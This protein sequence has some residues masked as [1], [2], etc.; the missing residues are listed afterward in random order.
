MTGAFVHTLPELVSLSGDS[1]DFNV[2]VL[3]VGSSS[4]EASLGQKTVQREIPQVAG[5]TVENVMVGLSS[6]ELWYTKS[7]DPQIRVAIQLA[8]GM[9]QPSISTSMETVSVHVNTT[10][11]NNE[12]EN[13]TI[14]TNHS[15]CS[16]SLSFGQHLFTHDKRHLRVTARV[17]SRT[18]SAMSVTLR[19]QL[20][21]ATGQPALIPSSVSA[22]VGEEVL[23]AARVNVTQTISGFSA[24]CNGT[25]NFSIQSEGSFSVLSD[26]MFGETV[27]ANGLRST[28][29]D[30]TGL[31]TLYNVR[32]YP[33]VRSMSVSCTLDISLENGER[34]V[35]QTTSPASIAVREKRIV[36][37]YAHAEKYT[38][39]N[40][41][42]VNGV[43][44]SYQL[45]WTVLYSTGEVSSSAICTSS[46]SSL[47]KVDSNCS[48]IYFDG[49]ET[50]G[51]SVRIT[52]MATGGSSVELSFTVWAPRGKMELIAEDQE[53]NL[54]ESCGRYQETRI[55]ALAIFTDGT[56]DIQV[57]L[58]PPL[59]G[60]LTFDGSYISQTTAGVVRGMSVGNTSVSVSSPMEVTPAFVS[61]V[62]DTVNT[63]YLDVF[64]VSDIEI[65][66]AS[67]EF[68]MLGSTQ[69]VSISVQQRTVRHSF[70][71]ELVAVAVFSDSTT[72][73]VDANEVSVSST[74]VEYEMPYLQPLEGS[75]ED[76]LDVMALCASGCVNVTTNSTPPVS[77]KVNLT[78]D[79]SSYIVPFSDPASVVGFPTSTRVKVYL[80]H[81]DGFEVDV[82]GSDVNI[83]VDNHLMYSISGGF[84][85]V[86]AQTGWTGGALVSVS[87]ENLSGSVSVTVANMD[88]VLVSFRPYPPFDGSDEVDVTTLHQTMGSSYQ[89]ALL[90]AKA[91]LTNGESVILK[92]SQIDITP[93]S[94]V[95][96][97]GVV[98]VD[99]TSNSV[100]VSVTVKGTAMSGQK[101]LTI[102]SNMPAVISIGR[103]W[104][105]G[106]QVDCQLTLSGGVQVNSLFQNEDPSNPL[107]TQL[108]EFSSDGTDAVSVNSTGFLTSLQNLR[109]TVTITVASGSVSNSTQYMP[110]VHPE[111]GEIDIGSETEF[112]L[113]PI[114]TN[115]N[116]T[117][118]VYLNTGPSSVG[119]AEVTLSFSGELNFVSADA[120]EDISTGLL[121]VEEESKKLRLGCVM[122]SGVLGER[123]ELAKLNFRTGGSTGSVTFSNGEVLYTTGT[124]FNPSKEN[125]DK[126]SSAVSFTQSV[127]S[128]S[129]RRR[130]A[131]SGA[132][133]DG[134]INGDGV[135]D[136]LDTVV[137]Q[138][139]SLVQS[140]GFT[141]SLGTSINSS[142]NI[143]TIQ[144]AVAAI[145]I[146]GDGIVSI[147]NV[148]EIERLANNEIYLLSNFS[149]S[150]LGDTCES[151]TLSGCL[152]D[153]DNEPPQDKPV[154]FLYITSSN[155]NFTRVFEGIVWSSSGTIVFSHSD[156]FGGSGVYGGVLEV[157]LQ[158]DSCFSITGTV[159]RTGLEGN[160]TVGV[161][162]FHGRVMNVGAP[163]EIQGSSFQ[164]L[165]GSGDKNTPPM[166]AVRL[167]NY[168]VGSGG[169]E[170]RF[171]EGLSY[172]RN[173]VCEQPITPP[174]SSSVIAPSSSVSPSTSVSV[175]AT[176]SVFTTSVVEP[177]TT[178]TKIFTSSEATSSS[179]SSP[180]LSESTRTTSSLSSA[181]DVSTTLTSMSSESV[182]PT[183]TVPSSSFLSSTGV[184]GVQTLSSTSSAS[185]PV[186]ETP[187]TPSTDQTPPTQSNIAIL[188]GAVAGVV[189]VIIVIALVVF[190]VVMCCGYRVMKKRDQYRPSEVRLNSFAFAN[191]SDYWFQA[192]EQ[193]E[194][195]PIDIIPVPPDSNEEKFHDSSQV[196]MGFVNHA[197]SLSDRT[198]HLNGSATKPVIGGQP[199]HM[200]SASVTMDHTHV[201]PSRP[202]ANG[203]SH[204]HS[205]HYEDDF[206]FAFDECVSQPYLSLGL[207][208]ASQLSPDHDT[209][210]FPGLPPPIS[211]AIHD[212]SYSI[213]VDSPVY[214]KTNPS[215][216]QDPV[217][218]S[219][220]T[221]RAVRSG[222]R[223]LKESLSH[224]R[225]KLETVLEDTNTSPVEGGGRMSKASGHSF[226]WSP[227]D[228]DHNRLDNL[229]AYMPG[230][231]DLNVFPSASLSA[232]QGSQGSVGNRS[233]R[234]GMP[235]CTSVGPSVTSGYIN[236]GSP[237]TRRASHDGS[238]IYP[239]TSSRWDDHDEP[240]RDHTHS[241]DSGSRHSW[242][243]K[244]EHQESMREI[245]REKLR[246]Q[247]IEEERAKRKDQEMRSRRRSDPEGGQYGP[248]VIQKAAQYD[249]KVDVMGESKHHYNLHRRSMSSYSNRSSVHSPDS[250][251][252]PHQDIH[253]PSHTTPLVPQQMNGFSGDDSLSPLSP[254]ISPQYTADDYSTTD[255]VTSL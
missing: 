1:Y 238:F 69:R 9:S 147:S 52:V 180:V 77:L 255:H 32:V 90:V 234:G 124:G 98:T 107:Y 141:T 235:R 242:R 21:V 150:T 88:Q 47:L 55:R 231:Q 245:T 241:P 191:G 197:F 81:R 19:T 210:Y 225:G 5:Q 113:R 198:S 7:Q 64:V 66:V 156:E 152:Q 125:E 196:D 35:G 54:I 127:V 92:T 159:D 173:T 59:L 79:S 41:A 30:S 201:Y 217:Y 205:G 214:I 172:L 228:T 6:N 142:S 49:S 62:N 148:V 57:Y 193:I 174:S 34:L 33:V 24:V 89:Q 102:S 229:P 137:L 181:V 78:A 16:V 153:G 221:R 67:G 143:S 136:L 39:L 226:K 51:G 101:T 164:I 224:S 114:P 213:S 23:L 132:P 126:I 158:N 10:D 145:D 175:P 154:L 130:Q 122:L 252:F 2:T 140:S 209:G 151:I 199:K 94:T 46:N 167:T 82:T 60:N 185:P 203:H 178:S 165:E 239:V 111:V 20:S 129:R 68:S 43:R 248:S 192:E 106:T 121:R 188:A 99:G 96:E 112:P 254:S 244:R 138:Y 18:S 166:S 118:P 184:L 243:S 220:H 251:G 247:V 171:V 31:K 29:G 233:R 183:E 40:T 73:V 146:D 12:W 26:P 14:P 223:D 53:L 139:Y 109:S 45:W 4:I 236:G 160:I 187:T 85:V 144:A 207:T 230:S 249:A 194:M 202:Q 13:C 168:T 37:V 80:V 75:S 170:V 38:L 56:T 253:S 93:Q 48:T 149:M 97:Q 190:A 216:K 218:T 25:G 212:S 91:T 155:V 179:V 206:D 208:P 222:P 95:S 119:V 189:V 105:T 200:E 61:V 232:G 250:M 169:A 163:N 211:P 71:H 42:R 246:R 177:V 84:I 237:E 15:F 162:V 161:N 27:Y 134:D 227:Q 83:T 128:S 63:L 50:S 157:G 17:G 195:S 116:F 240:E 103:V 8:D 186:S 104:I 219:G 70:V 3:A 100:T 74:A 120:G 182:R 36:S 28:S 131:T 176:S 135:V 133:L 87:Y 117:L 72:M 65:S 22:F 58:T 204:S 76:T 86:T 108:V 215:V 115:S 11:S 44:V 110:N 123:V